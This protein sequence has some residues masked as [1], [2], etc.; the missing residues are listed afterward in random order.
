[1]DEILTFQFH[2]A[3]TTPKM[4]NKVAQNVF[5]KKL[6]FS[7]QNNESAV[8]NDQTPNIRAIFLAT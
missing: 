1:M 4:G 7:H 3:V 8:L 6:A 5:P 2:W